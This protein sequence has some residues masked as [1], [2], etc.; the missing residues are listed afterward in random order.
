M[1]ATSL[2]TTLGDTSKVVTATALLGL[3]LAADGDTLA[4]LAQMENAAALAQ[5]SG[6]QRSQ[7]YTLFLHG[8]L[9]RK[10]G[11]YLN[12][13]PILTR[14]LESAIQ[15]F[16]LFIAYELALLY[17]Q[18]E[19]LKEATRLYHAVLDAPRPKRHAA[20]IEAE[21][22][23][24]KAENR[25]LMIESDRHHTRDRTA[26]IALL[27]VLLSFGFVFLFRRGRR[28]SLPVE[29]GKGGFYLPYEMPTGLTLSELKARF[30]TIPDITALAANR[31][32]YSYA[33]LPNT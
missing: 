19:Q 1:R 24:R 26:I 17:D 27:L 5:Q 22:K 10:S 32:A 8:Q 33:L 28:P 12:A 9:R 18:R 6:D 16:H 2:Y 4:G 20:A 13:E 14:A 11:D 15:E 29:Y 3:A 23:A 21:L 7:V 25:L 30:Q 31:L